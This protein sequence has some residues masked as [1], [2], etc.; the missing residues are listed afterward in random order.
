MRARAARGNPNKEIIEPANGFG[1]YRQLLNGLLEPVYLILYLLSG[2][3][4]YFL[5]LRTVNPQARYPTPIVLLHGWATQNPILLIL[6]KRL[7]KIGYRVYVPSFGWH[8]KSIETICK[9]L[10]LFIKTHRIGPFIC[11]GHSLG[12]IIALHYYTRYQG[13][14]EKCIALGS[15]FHGAPHARVF[16]FSASAQ[17]MIPESSFLEGLN[18]RNESLERFF[19]LATPC[20]EVVPASSSTVETGNNILIDAAGHVDLLLSRK[21]FQEIRRILQ[22][23]LCAIS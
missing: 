4:G 20:D 18:C 22:Q 3:C 21:V 19:S 2:L 7:E 12:G 8:F 16:W 17:E 1:C 9:K 14:L 5:T 15:P 23:P 13:S 6:K 11:I 10:D